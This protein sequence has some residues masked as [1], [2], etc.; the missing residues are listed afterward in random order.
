MVGRS[1]RTQGKGKGIVFLRRGLLMA[2]KDYLQVLKD[3]DEG[4]PDDGYN[5]LKLYFNN[6]KKIEDNDFDLMKNAFSLKAWQ[7]RNFDWKIKN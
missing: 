4:R 2:N 1:N 3:I 7:M 6:K 5:N